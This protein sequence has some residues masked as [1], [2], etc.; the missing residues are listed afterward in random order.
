M[1]PLDYELGYHI[2]AAVR[3]SGF[4]E[5]HRCTGSFL[6]TLMPT[7]DIGVF[8]MHAHCTRCL[9]TSTYSEKTMAGTMH[10][11]RTTATRRPNLKMLVENIRGGTLQNS[12]S[13]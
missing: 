6:T 1:N 9:E 13:H 5:N 12:C 3:H 8:S 7:L 4:W 10:G 2:R 11:W